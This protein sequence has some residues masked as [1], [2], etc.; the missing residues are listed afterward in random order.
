MK[1]VLLVC[2]ALGALIIPAAAADWTGFHV[3]AHVGFAF[4][5]EDASSGLF[6]TPETFSTNPSGFIGGLQAGYDYQFSPNWLVGAEIAQSW[7]A[8]S[9]NFN[10]STTT[11]GGAFATGIF[12]SN[13]NWYGTITGRLGYVTGDWVLYAKGG[14][15]WMNA[16]YNVAVTGPFAGGTINST[17]SGYAAGIG[18][19]WRFAPDWS[20]NLEY[21][22]LDFGTGSYALGGVGTTVDSHVQ[23]LK[24]GLNY[25]LRPGGLFGWF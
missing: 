14:A 8:A 25:H 5:G 11:P 1:K 21:D 22:Y 9:G 4:A 18:G 2:M 17:R 15:A 20:T 23:L 24:V 6:G 3:G 19:E 16:D 7:S 12:D 13:Q 10:F